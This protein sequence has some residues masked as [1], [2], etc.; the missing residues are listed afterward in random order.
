MHYQKGTSFL[1]SRVLGFE[2]M[3]SMYPNDEDFKEIHELCVRHPHGL[4]HK[5]QGFLFKGTRLCIPE[6]G[7]RELL[8]KEVPGGALP[9]HF[10]IEKT[11]SMLKEHYYCAKMTKDVE[12]LVKGCSTY[13]LA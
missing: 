5:E 4:F 2:V 6:G 10:G 8:I 9:G 1:D 12:H 3:K 7:T 11:C 13:Q